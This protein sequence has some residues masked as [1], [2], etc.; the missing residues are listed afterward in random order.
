MALL[1]LYDAALP[2]VYGYL[3]PRC[4]NRTLAEDLTA[5]SFLAAVAAVRKPEAPTPSIPWLIGVAR[6]KLIDHWRRT[7]AGGAQPPARPRRRAGR[8]RSLGRAPRRPSGPRSAG[9]IGFP[10]PGSADAALR[11]WPAGPRGRRAS[12][13]HGARHRGVAGARPA[14][15]PSPLRGRG[16]R[17]WLTLGMPWHFPSSRSTPIRPSRRA[18]VANCRTP[19]SLLRP[20]GGENHHDRI[21]TARNG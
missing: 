21:P 14:G 7:G 8:C 10:P 5:E 20:H 18:C 9:G 17:R 4:G 2:Q 19:C 13:T 12:R 11:R 15:V 3:L 1:R 16:G 6:H